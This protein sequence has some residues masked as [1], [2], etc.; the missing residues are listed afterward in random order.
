MTYLDRF[1]TNVRNTPQARGIF[2]TGTPI[3]S[4]IQEIHGLLD[5]LAHDF[6]AETH[7]ASS[8]SSAISIGKRIVCQDRLGTNIGKTPKHRRCANVSIGNKE[9]WRTMLQDPFSKDHSPAGLCRMRCKTRVFCTV[10][11]YRKRSFNQDR[12]GTHVGK[13]LK[14]KTRFP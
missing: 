3:A 6:G 1:G 14:T 8:S 11:Q 5:F 7:A 2:D 13:A 10:F 4:S 9:L 12:L